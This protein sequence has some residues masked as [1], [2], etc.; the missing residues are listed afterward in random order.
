MSKTMV[1][2]PYDLIFFV[3]FVGPSSDLAYRIHSETKEG[4]TRL[5]EIK[6]VLKKI[7]PKI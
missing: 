4:H 7:A 1:Q 2:W 6:K 3:S 5:V